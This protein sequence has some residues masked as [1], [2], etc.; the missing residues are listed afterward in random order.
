M[1]SLG[2]TL[3]PKVVVA[4]RRS[5]AVVL[6]LPE[7]VV[8]VLR[9]TV[10]KDSG[11]VK[12]LKALWPVSRRLVSSLLVT[13]SAAL[14][15]V[16]VMA[17]AGAAMRPMSAMAAEA[18]V[19]E[20]LESEFGR[21]VNLTQVN[22]KSG[23]ALEDVCTVESKDVCQSGKPSSEPGGFEFP[24]G[25]AVNT[26][27]STA[28]YG[29]VYVIDNN[30]RVQVLTADGRLVRMFGWEVNATK[31]AQPTATRAEKNVCTAASADVCKAGVEGT[32]PGQLTLP[33][34]Y[35]GLPTARFAHA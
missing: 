31:D 2:K 6:G 18:P 20:V 12:S 26:T 30:H 35:H 19:K 9:E 16:G 3:G 28:D 10:T 22:A 14:S 32:Q 7:G 24:R 11:A 25:V 34:R 1:R 29:Y 5:G 15:L 27:P 8:S 21:E 23:P 33:R 4:A 13:S 17:A